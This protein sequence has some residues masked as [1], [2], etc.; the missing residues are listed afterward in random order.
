MFYSTEYASKSAVR[1]YGQCSP[2][3]CHQLQQLLFDLLRHIPKTN[4]PTYHQT[5]D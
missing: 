2:C 3:D 4:K 1:Y 5:V